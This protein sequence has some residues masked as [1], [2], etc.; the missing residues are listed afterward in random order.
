MT[1]IENHPIAIW[2]D[3]PLDKSRYAK[4]HRPWYFENYLDTAV[5][6]NGIY[7]N[8]IRECAVAIDRAPHTVR[9]NWGKAGNID[10]LWPGPKSKYYLAERQTDVNHYIPRC[11]EKYGLKAVARA[12]NEYPVNL[13]HRRRNGLL[14]RYGFP[15]NQDNDSKYYSTEEA[16]VSA[17]EG[18][19]S[20]SVCTPSSQQAKVKS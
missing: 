16:L 11:I 15:P 17:I 1:I 4:N 6:W 8:T 18:Q 2:R 19:M 12:L 20:S 7:F 5:V 14:W 3:K 9:D 10:C 13:R